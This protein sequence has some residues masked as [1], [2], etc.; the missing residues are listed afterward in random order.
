MVGTVVTKDAA[1]VIAERLA[2]LDGYAGE[3]LPQE[4]VAEAEAV[5]DALSGAGFEIVTFST[6]EL[7]NAARMRKAVVT[8]WEDKWRS[9]PHWSDVYALAGEEELDEGD[10][11]ASK[12]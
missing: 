1:L 2:A 11:V 4:Y 5:M 10:A 9:F 7:A 12:P 8:Y 3:D 6:A